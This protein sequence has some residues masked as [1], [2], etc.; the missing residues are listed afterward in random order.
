MDTAST[1]SSAKCVSG[2]FVLLEKV[3]GLASY[4]GVALR[5]VREGNDSLYTRCTRSAENGRRGIVRRTRDLHVETITQ[6]EA[7]VV[8]AIRSLPAYRP[9]KIMRKSAATSESCG[10]RPDNR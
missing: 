6:A 4:K 7:Q 2:P 8:A 1:R 3:E 10:P 5:F 9:K